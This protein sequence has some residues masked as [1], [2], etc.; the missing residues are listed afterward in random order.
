MQTTFSKTISKYMED[1]SLSTEEFSREIGV[2]RAT[3]ERWIA[4]KTSPAEA[5]RVGIYSYIHGEKENC[6]GKVYG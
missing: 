2:G 6:K 3:V 5:I 1:Y 4:G